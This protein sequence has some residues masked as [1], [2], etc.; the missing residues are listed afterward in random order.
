MQGMRSVSK[1]GIHGRMFTSL[2][3]SDETC[4][5]TLSKSSRLDSKF[6]KTFTA[7]GK[8]LSLSVIPYIRMDIWT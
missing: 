3:L 4:H 6:K 8:S 5:H 1:I 7:L 2:A